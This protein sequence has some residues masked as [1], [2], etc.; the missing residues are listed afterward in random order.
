MFQRAA[1]CAV[2]GGLISW[3]GVAGAQQNDY[4]GYDIVGALE[5]TERAYGSARGWTVSAANDRGRFAYCAGAYRGNGYDIR[6]GYDGGQWQL[7]VPGRSTPDWEGTLD[8]DGDRRTSGGTAVGNWTIAWLRLDELDRLARGDHAELS[9][10]T[11]HYSFPLTGT[12][13]TITKIEECVRRKGLVA[14]AQAAQQP[15]RQPPPP[16]A[17]LPG[18]GEANCFSKVWGPYR[19][20]IT[21]FPPESGYHRASRI[22]PID[23]PNAKSFF[24]RYLDTNAE[25]WVP[26]SQGATW[27]YLGVWTFS[28]HAKDCIEPMGYGAQSPEAQSNLG[29][30]DWN[31]CVQQQ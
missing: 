29:P 19:C 10:R 22:D 20:R 13:A 5:S 14:N 31:L 4:G 12:A 15:P 28:S 18:L 6:I 7:A 25:V 8:V 30:R 24:I 16:P 2:L 27:A 11:T 21:D 17:S 3:A 26:D 1:V 23:F 9:N